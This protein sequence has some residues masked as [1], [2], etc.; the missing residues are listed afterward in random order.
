MA[1]PTTASPTGSLPESPPPAAVVD[2]VA[3][4]ARAEARASVAVATPEADADAVESRPAETAPK[5]DANAEADDPSASPAAV[6]PELVELM[7]EAMREVE[8]V[9]P[10]S[11][12]TREDATAAAAAAAEEEEE[13]EEEAGT[14]T[15]TRVERAGAGGE[16]SSSKVDA[17]AAV[18]GGAAEPTDDAA[19]DSDEDD[20][21]SVFLGS[22]PAAARAPA[23]AAV[24]AEEQVVESPPSPPRDVV[25]AEKK[26]P[27]PT[28]PTPT[29]PPPVE[30]EA[31]PGVDV[32]D[33]FL[34]RTVSPG[35]GNESDSADDAISEFLC[36]PHVVNP[37]P[38]AAAARLLPIRPRSRGER[39]SLR[40]REASPPREATPPPTTP[41]SSARN[42]RSPLATLPSPPPPSSPP[43]PAKHQKSPQKTTRDEW[44]TAVVLYVTSMSTVRATKDK[45][46]RA[47]AATRALGVAN[48]I[49]RDVAAAC[50]YKE[51]LRGRLAALGPGA[52]KGLVVPYL[53]AGDVAV[54]GGD[55]LDAL[56]C[57]GGLED[58]LKALGARRGDDE[59]NEEDEG[60]ENAKKKACGGCGGRGFVVC[61]K[62]RGSMRVHCV[63]VTR[64]CFACNEVGMTECVACVP[65]FA[66]TA[67]SSL[68]SGA[69]GAAVRR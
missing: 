18:V 53:F 68:A 19:Y 17:A 47:R 37:A 29:P 44:K 45:C 30:R 39:H 65:A 67:A 12:P 5:R 27:K 1:R 63:D 26:S 43:P 6:E 54:A 62:C 24:V 2:D 61:V 22:P 13:E 36:S 60:D 25:A 35:G 40:N 28:T 34:A 59:E 32:I 8:V 33:A 16:P 42:G 49:E 50:A 52:G 10:P 56:V 66:R 23:K 41:P 7:M 48:A 46:E 4:N 64:R 15:G 57:E 55:D 11:T 14:E 9:E 51:E 38:A 31:S 20:V 3:E 21:I 58:A 69:R